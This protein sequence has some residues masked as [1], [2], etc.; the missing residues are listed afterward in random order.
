[1]RGDSEQGGNG[2]ETDADTD[3]GR[4][5]EEAEIILFERG[6]HLFGA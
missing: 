6:P 3:R 4:L 1:M 2:N 5:S